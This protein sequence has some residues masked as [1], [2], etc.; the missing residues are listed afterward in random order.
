MEAAARIMARLV[1]NG[2]SLPR[3]GGLLWQHR[4]T[5][6]D[7]SDEI[8]PE[9]ENFHHVHIKKKQKKGRFRNHKN[10]HT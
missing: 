6:L 10:L 7:K 1:T 9:T 5:K 8:R 4:W 3:H 2:G